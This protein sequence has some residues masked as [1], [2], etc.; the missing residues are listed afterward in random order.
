MAAWPF[1]V[2]WNPPRRR[3]VGLVVVGLL[4]LA[5]CAIAAAWGWGW[6]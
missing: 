5:A 1:Q 6:S 4:T 2:S 3:T